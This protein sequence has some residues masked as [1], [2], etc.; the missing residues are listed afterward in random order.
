MM[1]IENKKINEKYIKKKPFKNHSI[2]NKNLKIEISRKNQKKK[3]IAKSNDCKN[4]NKKYSKP[5]ILSLSKFINKKNHIINCSLNNKNNKIKKIKKL[6]EFERVTT[7]NTYNVPYSNRTYIYNTNNIFINYQKYSPYKNKKSNSHEKNQNFTIYNI[8][9]IDTIIKRKMTKYFHN[10]PDKKFINYKSLRDFNIIN[11]FNYQ[12]NQNFSRKI[13]FNLN[14]SNFSKTFNFLTDI[15]YFM[16]H[17]DENLTLSSL[18]RRINYKYVNDSIDEKKIND[19]YEFKFIVQ[20]W[21]L[22]PIKLYKYIKHQIIYKYGHFFLNELDKINGERKEY[23]KK[24]QLLNIIKNIKEKKIIKYYFRKFRDNTLIEKIKKIYQDYYKNE[25]NKYNKIKENNKKKLNNL[26]KK[27]RLYVT[28]KSKQAKNNNN[29]IIK[30][31]DIFISKLKLMFY[32]NNLNRYYIYLKQFLI[33][34]YNNK[35]NNIL[36][37]EDNKIIK[38]QKRHIKI[39]YIKKISKSIDERNKNSISKASSSNYS[40]STINSAK[41]MNVYKRIVY[42]N[43]SIIDIKKKNLDLIMVDIILKICKNEKKQYFSIWK[44]IA[45]NK[46]KKNDKRFFYYFLAKLVYYKKN[47]KQMNYNILLGSAMYIWKRYI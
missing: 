23:N 40:K 12:N 31:V 42:S 41:K 37:N 32:R 2:E 18:K 10:F 24:Y 14:Q 4:N 13:R 44:K 11:N 16:Y 27:A 7:Y 30:K 33:N 3:K 35:A 26:R 15:N 21:I 28:K 25:I 20:N 22:F 8:N 29:I 36:F 43:N 39:K 45:F 17:N 34:N 47:I 46:N 9:K 1:K 38:K 6:E 19:Y 5:K